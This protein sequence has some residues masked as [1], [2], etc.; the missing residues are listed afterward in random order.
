MKIV[1]STCPEGKRPVDTLTYRDVCV[2]N[3]PLFAYQNWSS[4]ISATLGRTMLE[5][6]GQGRKTL[7]PG[8]AQN[9]LET[10]QDRTVVEDLNRTL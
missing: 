2:E 6:S 4:V 3:H 10:A 8:S 9:A 5:R 7:G 1:P